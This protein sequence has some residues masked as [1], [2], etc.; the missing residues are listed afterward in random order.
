MRILHTSDWHLGQHFIGK[1][2]AAEHA[3][4]LRWLVAQADELSID[5][6]VVAG[7]V[8]DTAT[9]PSYARELYNQFIVDLQPTGCQLVILGGNHDSP[10]VLA[11]SKRLLARLKTAVIP[12]TAADLAEQ[13][14]VL[15]DQQSE[16][17]CLLAAVPFIRP[18]DVLQSQAGQSGQQKQQDLQQAIASHYQ[19]L[20]ALAQSYN[21]QHKLQLPIVMTGH[22]TTVGVSQSE[23]VRD[24]YIGTLE[25]FS[26]SQFPPAD[27]IALGHIHQAQ[28]LNSTTD[29]RYSG[30][31]IPLSFDEA[32]Q[33]KQAWLVEFS[34]GQKKVSSI[35][36]PCFQPLASIKTD[37]ASLPAMLKPLLASLGGDKRLWLEVVIG[38]SDGYLTDLQPRVEQLLSDLPV[39]LL[40]LRRERSSVTNLQQLKQTSLAELSPSDV[41]QARLADEVL[42]AELQQ[43]LTALYQQVLAKVLDDD[44]HSDLMANGDST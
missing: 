18:R 27:Y 39:E 5:A 13:L 16:P 6:I 23:S 11:E 41:W 25:A 44:Q 26:A 9:P 42:S 17:A 43:Q 10:A 36:I 4:F 15:T 2:R 12:A 34:A 7:D 19:Q 3:A 29:I 28:Q 33:Q 31:P 35:A 30:S 8:F 14:L 22:L 20:F 40:R 1:S 24:I 32:R 38:Q 37:L 21:Q